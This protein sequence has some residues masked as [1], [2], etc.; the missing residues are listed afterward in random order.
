M[1]AGLLALLAGL[2]LAAS[3]EAR[4]LAGFEQEIP[5]V[6]E[7]SSLGPDL[8]SCSPAD[9]FSPADRPGSARRA[10]GADG[11]FP[12]QGGR[13]LVLSTSPGDGSP[14]DLRQTRWRYVFDVDRPSLLTLAAAFRT[15]DDPRFGDWYLVSLDGRALACASA[16]TLPLDGG[17][18]GWRGIGADGSLLLEPGRHVL[19]AA[20]GDGIDAGG[21]SELLID[22]IELRPAQEAAQAQPPTECRP[23]PP[24]EVGEIPN[25][26]TL[27]P[28]TN[29]SDPLVCTSPRRVW[30]FDDNRFCPNGSPGRDADSDGLPDCLECRRPEDVGDPNPPGGCFTCT[31]ATDELFEMYVVADCGTEMHLPLNDVESGCISILDQDR[32]PITITVD[33]GAGFFET[34]TE[35]CWM[36]EDCDGGG[37]NLPGGPGDARTMDV[38]FT[39]EP[40]LCGVFIARFRSWAGCIWDLFANCDGTNTEQFFIFDDFCEAEDAYDPLPELIVENLTT[41]PGEDCTVDYCATVRNI[42][43]R[44]SMPHEL[45]VFNEAGEH[46]H[47]IG[48]LMPGDSE[49]VCDTLPVNDTGADPQLTQVVARSDWDDS[50]LECTEDP[51]ASSCSALTG[52]DIVSRFQPVNCNTAPFCDAGGP[53]EAECGAGG[54]PGT[55]A[56]P[57][58]GTGSSDPEGQPLSYAWTTT[59]PGASFDDPASPTPTLLLPGAA[60]ELSCE[61]GLT[62]TD[63][64]G[65]QAGCADSVFVTDTQPP[66]VIC[67][68]EVD[69]QCG[70]AGVPTRNEW[71]DQASALDSCD[72]DATVARSIQFASSPCPDSRTEIWEFTAIDACGNESEPCEATWRVQ[73]TIPPVLDL[74]DDR[75]V[76]C[77]EDPDA[78]AEAW[79]AQA[80]AEDACAGPRLVERELVSVE[81]GCGGTETRTYRFTAIDRCG[82]SVTDTRTWT[83]VD[84]GLPTLVGVPPDVSVDCDAVPAPANVGANDDCDPLPVVSLAETMIPGPCPNSFELVRTW[85]ATDGCGNSVSDEQRITVVDD[86]PPTLEGVP[87]DETVS[88]DQVPPPAF[89]SIVD[90]CDP[91]PALVVDEERIDGDCPDRYQLIRTWTGSDGCGNQTVE[92]QTLTV[93]DS[94]PPTLQGVPADTVALCNAVPPPAFVSASDDCD[95][96]PTVVFSETTEPGSCPQAGVLVRTW[97]ATDRCGNSSS[98]E[99]RI[100]I[101]DPSPPFL[102]GVPPDAAVPCDQVPPPASPSAIDDCDPDPEIAFSETTSPGDCP[103]RYTITRTWTATDDCGN[104]MSR[105]QVLTVEDTSPPELQGVPAGGVVSCDAVPPPGDV[106]AVDDCDPDPLVEIDETVVPGPCPDEYQIVRTWTATDRCG[107]SAFGEQVLTVRDLQSP[108]LEGVPAD[109]T[110]QCDA[111]PPPPTVTASDNCDPNP[112]VSFSEMQLPGSCPDQYQLVR[113]WTAIDRCGNTSSDQQVLSVVDTQAPELAGVPADDTVECDAVP[114][115]PA[116]TA[117]DDCDPDPAVSYTEV[118]LPGA[119][120]DRYQLVRTWTATDRCGNSSVDEQVLTVVDTRAPVLQGVPADETAECDAVPPPAAPTATD[121]CDPDPAIAFSELRTDGDCPFRYTLTRTWTATDRCG[122][123]SQQVQVVTVV[124]TTPPVLSAPPDLTVECPAPASGPMSEDGWRALA[125]ATDNCGTPEVFSAELSRTLLCGATYEA[126]FEFWAVDECGN[127]SAREQRTYLVEDTTPPEIFP[128]EDFTVECPAPETGPDSEEA[129]RGLATATDACGVPEVFSELV[130]RIPGCGNTYTDLWDFW[131]VDECGNASAPLR[132]QYEVVDT[133]P[134]VFTEG[135]PL[136]DESLWPPQHGYV[137]FETGEMASATDAC[138]EVTLAISGCASSQPE[139]VHLGPTEDGGNGDGRFFEDCVWAEDGSAFAARAERLGACGPFSYRLYSVEVTATDECGNSATASGL[140]RVEHDRRGKQDVRRGRKLGPNDPPPW[141]Y[142]HDTLYGEGC[143]ERS[144][145]DRR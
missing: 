34:G 130:E 53:Y 95:P 121:N 105:T 61:V 104:E 103:D 54:P 56:I 128:P 89:V 45:Q 27:P 73:D 21:R 138:G 11:G 75:L 114:P 42:G 37:A 41:T 129:W 80:T 93:D 125:T 26:C 110:V 2:A 96:N 23:A 70:D 59:C 119:C 92:S 83:S 71:L 86:D 38:R 60:C 58:D 36:A 144:R 10:E 29:C 91:F 66:S 72:P 141:P 13:A 126:V 19:E 40:A 20:V 7:G 65:L 123:E 112:A 74:P 6:I 62:V 131:A 16:G 143:G 77:P 99:Q 113:T 67:P 76:E 81:P 3:A 107:N 115:P 82:N 69:A 90:D 124:D 35:V 108:Q 68:A 135:E 5:G 51:T 117:S 31:D 47:S 85:T 12:A 49:M 24:E 30:T 17:R 139:E 120:P 52:G 9:L 118:Q 106:T 44:L 57:L 46:F 94:R 122:N 133:T 1:R 136:F 84:T 101:L 140:L 32:N 15:A 109:D 132:R 102:S 98:A 142:V 50:L 8:P 79:A 4:L 145:S 137:V 78:D 111:V 14:D 48:T 22:A 64:D 127:E 33:N 87:E 18:S 25:L 88:C 43:C 116:V 39:A 55:T 97:T 100:E 28:L 63:P 134:P